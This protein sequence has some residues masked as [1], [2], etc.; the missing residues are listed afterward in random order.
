MSIFPAAH[1]LDV[2]IST[3]FTQPIDSSLLSIARL[4]TDP[5]YYADLDY[6]NFQIGSSYKTIYNDIQTVISTGTVAVDFTVSNVSANDATEVIVTK[7]RKYGYKEYG[8]TIA[9]S[10]AGAVIYGAQVVD[11]NITEANEATVAGYVGY[12]Y[13]AINNAFTVP[14]LETITRAYDYGIYSAS[15]LTNIDTAYPLSTVAGNSYT[16]ATGWTLKLFDDLGGV[17]LSGNAEL[18]TVSN[19]TNFHVSGRVTFTAAGTYTLDN[20][21]ITEVI[22]A[23][24]G[25]IINLTNGSAITNNLSPANITINNTQSIKIIVKDESTGALNTQARVHMIASGGGTLPDGTVIINH[26]LVDANGEINTTVNA[27]NQGFTGIVI[28]A[29]SPNL[30]VPKPI[31]GTIPAGGLNLTVGLVKD[32]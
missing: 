10:R 23:I 25:V 16:I 19:L 27:S 31:S 24:A 14:A 20:T 3:S 11:N 7:A 22:S 26:Q 30:Y 32:E 2:N 21:T 29:A 9:H 1:I 28:D 17:S 8:S 13:D 12:N 6:T 4:P 18:Q 5:I 15:L